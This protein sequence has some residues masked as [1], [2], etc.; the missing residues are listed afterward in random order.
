MK[1][2]EWLSVKESMEYLKV[3]SKSTVYS[4]QKKYKI[5]VSKVN[6]ITYFR[7]EDFDRMFEA[8]ATLRV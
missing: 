1:N 3:K 8:N 5:T 7:I 4:I 2:M 6:S